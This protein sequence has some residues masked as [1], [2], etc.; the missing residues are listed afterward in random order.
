MSVNGG[1]EIVPA[2]CLGCGEIM[3]VPEILQLR[4]QLHMLM[5]SDDVS[6]H[7]VC[8]FR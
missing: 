5:I 8:S 4:P 1:H 3:M 2:G 7:R 6:D